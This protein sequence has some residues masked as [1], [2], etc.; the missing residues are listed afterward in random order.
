MGPIK[1]PI[2]AIVLLK[3]LKVS[4][5]RLDSDQAGCR[6]DVPYDLLQT[7]E[8]QTTPLHLKIGIQ[9]IGLR[10]GADMGSFGV[11]VEYVLHCI[12]IMRY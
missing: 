5:S 10:E 12:L 9:I 7:P 1:W 2:I 6:F 3:V 8:P 11:D 4:G